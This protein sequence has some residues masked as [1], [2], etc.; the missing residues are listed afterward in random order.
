MNSGIVPPEISPEDAGLVLHRLVTERVP[1]VALF[2]TADESVKAKLLGHVNSFT[3]DS[4]LAICTPYTQNKPIPA[5]LQFPHDVVAAARFS[6]TD[7]SELPKDLVLGSGLRIL[8]PN[9]GDLT[10]V[11]VRVALD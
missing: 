2:K 10:I 3:R 1:V 6:Y 7:E 4:G 8:M 5:T 9:G 11:E